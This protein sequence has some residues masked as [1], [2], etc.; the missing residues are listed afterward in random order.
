MNSLIILVALPLLGRAAFSDR[1]QKPF[2]DTRTDVVLPLILDDKLHYSFQPVSEVSTAASLEAL[3]TVHSFASVEAIQTVTIDVPL[4]SSIS[5]T[6][7]FSQSRAQY[8]TWFD[9][10]S[11]FTWSPK[12]ARDSNI[13][14]GDIGIRKGGMKSLPFCCK[15]LVLQLNKTSRSTAELDIF[16][17]L[18]FGL[19]IGDSDEDQEEEPRDEI[20]VAP[21]QYVLKR[22]ADTCDLSVRSLDERTHG[23]GIAS[24]GCAA[25]RGR[26]LVLDWGKS[27]LGFGR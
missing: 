19:D 5:G 11:F 18:V 6:V 25:I 8:E 16:P 20:V 7:A 10:A 24:L 3:Q 17:D 12:H 26:K 21:E 1:Q 9:E 13:P 22:E 14:L 23:S 15:Q 27:R 4:D 2:V